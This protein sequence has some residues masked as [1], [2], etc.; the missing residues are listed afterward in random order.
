VVAPAMLVVAIVRD[1]A[2]GSVLA[3][4]LASRGAN[5]LSATCYAPIARR[6][7]SEPAILIVDEAAM[8]GEQ[9]D[10]I[11]ALWQEQRWSRVVVLTID[12]PLPASDR[13]WL[14]FADRASAAQTLAQL[15]ESPLPEAA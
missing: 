5:L 11:A 13:D 14:V 1:L 10:W 15:V 9:G 2:L 12:A 4:E 6:R 7:L 8:E 3:A